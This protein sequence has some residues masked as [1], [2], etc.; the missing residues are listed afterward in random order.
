[1]LIQLGLPS[2]HEL[3]DNDLIKLPETESGVKSTFSTVGLD[4]VMFTDVI[5]CERTCRSNSYTG[6]LE[7]SLSKDTNT[8]SLLVSADFTVGF[9]LEDSPA[10]VSFWVYRVSLDLMLCL[11]ELEL[12]LVVSEESENA[13]S[14]FAFLWLFVFLVFPCRDFCRG[15]ACGFVVLMPQP[16]SSLGLVSTAEGHFFKVEFGIQLRNSVGRLALLCW[17]VNTFVVTVR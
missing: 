9:E 12:M 13:F 10:V 15:M 7:S 5:D 3:N 16:S 6:S 17:S 14:L 4:I 1:M 8:S 11:S 2:S